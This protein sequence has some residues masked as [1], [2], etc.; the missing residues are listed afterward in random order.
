MSKAVKYET[1][2]STSIENYVIVQLMDSYSNPVLSQQENLA[3]EI[4]A[5]NGSH[6]YP[7]GFIENHNGTYTGGYV[8]VDPGIYEISVSFN[9]TRFSPFPSE[10][11]AYDSDVFPK[12]Q[13]DRVDV[14]EDQ[15]ISF[16]ALENDFFVGGN[17]KLV[18]FQKVSFE[19]SDILFIG[20]PHI[21]YRMIRWPKYLCPVDKND[22]PSH[23]SVLQYE[24]LLRYTPYK[25]YYGSDTF[26]YTFLDV[27][28]IYVSASVNIDVLINPPQFVSIPRVLQATEDTPSPKFGGFQGF[29][30]TYSD[31]QENISVKLSAQ[32]GAIFLSPF[33]MQLWDPMWNELSVSKEEGKVGYLYLTGR[34]EVL[35]LAIQSLR[36]IGEENFYGND[37]ITISTINTNGKYDFSVKIVVE[38][39]NDAPFIDR[40]K[41][42]GVM[43][44]RVN[45][46]GRYGCYPD[47]A[48]M[49]L[50]P[51]EAEA[52][53]NLIS[54]MPINSVVAHSYQLYFDF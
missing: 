41:H 17:A 20:D 51:L 44:V 49:K 46:M 28:G 48:D 52:T 16:Y 22:A 34:L 31:F 32:Y 15:S 38:P 40:G 10:D 43:R 3:V 42:A 27:H 29:M 26:T 39:I 30:L 35:N 18:G 24:N 12:A 7:G 53:I 6:S 47:C 54:R 21:C 23:G 36:Y 2:V 5:V 50:V 4:D 9:G 45:D 37:N 11:I 33:L 25:R 8:L 19:A 14:W 1:K 13:D